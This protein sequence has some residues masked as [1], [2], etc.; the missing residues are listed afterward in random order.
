MA[1]GGLYRAKTRYRACEQVLLL[2]ELGSSPVL[3]DHASEEPMTLDRGVEQGHRGG[4][5]PWWVLIDALVWAVVIEVLGV[6]VEDG[7][8]M[9]L[10]VDQQ[11]VDALVT[12]ATNETV[13]RSSSPGAFGDGS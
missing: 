11:P 13:P 2:A 12:D 4:V 9:S 3:V 6:L 7:K 10:V 8:G 1:C 5:V